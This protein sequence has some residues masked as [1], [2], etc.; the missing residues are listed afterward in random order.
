MTLIATAFSGYA[1]GHWLALLVMGSIVDRLG[2]QRVLPLTL[3]PMMLAML[4]LALYEHDYIPLLYLTLTGFT[5][6]GMSTASGTL[7][8]TRYGVRHLGSIRAMVQAVMVA[9][10]ALAPVLAGLILDAALGVSGLAWFM[11]AVTLLSAL[12]ALMAAD[13]P[14]AAVA[15]EDSDD[16][17]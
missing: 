15:K 2:A 3:L 16:G 8:P 12:L 6:G 1:A 13:H 9:A 17:L 5:Q 14:R 10:T 11:L 4:L 7:W